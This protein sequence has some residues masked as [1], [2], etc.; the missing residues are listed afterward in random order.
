V[1]VSWDARRSIMLTRC[2]CSSAS[3]SCAEIALA[4]SITTSP[5]TR[6]R[7]LAGGPPIHHWS[8]LL[9][10]RSVGGTEP[11][12]NHRNRPI[13]IDSGRNRAKSESREFP[14]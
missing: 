9:G 10:G 5:A 1:P 8:S 2:R 3:I 11:V 6:R 7:S 14:F 13:V 12:G 4:N